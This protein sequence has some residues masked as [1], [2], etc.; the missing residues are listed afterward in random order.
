M[1]AIRNYLRKGKYRH[2]EGC[3]FFFI[4]AY[5]IHVFWSEQPVHAAHLL[6]I[7]FKVGATVIMAL[8]VV[9][10]NLRCKVIDYAI[11]LVN[12]VQNYQTI[13]ENAEACGRRL[14]NIVL[15]SV[16]T[17]V[18]FLGMASMSEVV[19]YLEYCYMLAGGLFAYCMVM[20]IHVLFCFEELESIILNREL[21][22]RQ[23]EDRKKAKADM[24]EARRQHADN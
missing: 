16:S 11:K 18:L 20:Y 23:K 2:W 3:V 10:Y 4:I 1:S 9:A 6:N 5:F 22:N 13:A 8:G 7:F 17:S 15:I 21:R 19:P 12:T 24:A 14:T